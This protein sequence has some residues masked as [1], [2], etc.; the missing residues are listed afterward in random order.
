[1]D[2]QLIWQPMG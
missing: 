1:M 2:L